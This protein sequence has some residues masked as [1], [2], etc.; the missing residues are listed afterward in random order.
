MPSLN[1]A[2]EEYQ[3]HG[4]GAL[5][6]PPTV[7]FGPPLTVKSFFS[8]DSFVA[9]TYRPTADRRPRPDSSGR[10]RVR[11]GSAMSFISLKQKVVFKKYESNIKYYYYHSE[12][13]TTSLHLKWSIAGASRDGPYATECAV[14]VIKLTD[15]AAAQIGAVG[16]VGIDLVEELPIKSLDFKKKKRI[17]QSPWARAQAAEDARALDT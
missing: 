4:H 5:R 13:E 12:L 2:P 14:R 17:A 11:K 1:Y 16:R 7:A 10:G 6:Q 15:R 8:E 9:L 3:G